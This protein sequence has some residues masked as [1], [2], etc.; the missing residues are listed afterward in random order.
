[1][2]HVFGLREET[3]AAGETQSILMGRTNSLKLD[4]HYKG[5]TIFMLKLAMLC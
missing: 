4:R 1:M 3:I 2:L 5:L